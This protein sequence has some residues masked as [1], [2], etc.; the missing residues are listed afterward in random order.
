[1]EAAA[2]LATAPPD[3]ASSLIYP[4]CSVGQLNTPCSS[5]HAGSCF[6]RR[7]N[8]TDKPCTESAPEPIDC[9]RYDVAPEPD[10][11][12]IFIACVGMPTEGCV[13][14]RCGNPM[15]MCLPKACARRLLSAGSCREVQE[16]TSKPG[17]CR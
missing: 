12:D 9:A 8:C 5:R 14:E 17:A 10:A 13:V 6:L 4:R 2:P 7:N 11:C 16:L 3:A 15:A 1:V